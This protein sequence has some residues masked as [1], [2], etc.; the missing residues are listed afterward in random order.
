MTLPYWESKA[1]VQQTKHWYLC[2]ERGGNMKVPITFGE[3]NVSDVRPAQLFNVVA[4]IEGQ[5]KWDNSMSEAK[6]VKDFPDDGVLAA[7]L[8]FP[9][10]FWLVP[11]RQV[12][13]WMAFN[14]SLEEQEYWFAV[15]SLNVEAI[16]KEQ[17]PNQFAV[18]AENC[19]GAYWIRP[20]PRGGE[21][22]CP[23][24]NPYDC[25]PEGGSRIIF[26]THINV[27]P[28]GFLNAKTMFDLSWTKQIDWIKALKDRARE[29]L[30]S[31]ETFRAAQ[32][33][34]LPKWL[35]QDPTEPTKGSVRFSF[36]HEMM[37]APSKLYQRTEPFW[38]F[39][40]TSPVLFVALAAAVSVLIFVAMRA[41]RALALIKETSDSRELLARRGHT[42]DMEHLFSRR[43]TSA[44]TDLVEPGI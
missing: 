27:H 11:P 40:S 44:E 39:P 20:C 10:G 26:T 17:K 19:L 15:S 31:N 28:P 23:S 42:S 13:Q 43:F 33:P 18:Q 3:F 34:V 9:S 1:K 35:W 14:A 36:P 7:D 41:H 2:D 5:L 24:G 16:H 12:F 30:K 25:C 22:K 4:D 6:V 29:V 37:I 21:N 38:S 8:S 32:T